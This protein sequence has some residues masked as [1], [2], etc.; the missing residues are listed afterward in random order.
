MFD[1]RT[2]AAKGLVSVE[3]IGKLLRSTKETP[4]TVMTASTFPFFPDTSGSETD[5]V[6]TGISTR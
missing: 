4:P 6:V 5:A 3:A 2:D 1:V